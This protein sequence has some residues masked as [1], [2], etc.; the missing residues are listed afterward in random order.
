MAFTA[1]PPPLTAQKQTGAGVG[2]C[3]VQRP[4]SRCPAV[5]RARGGSWGRGHALTC[6][7]RPVACLKWRAWFPTCISHA[8]M[9]AMKPGCVQSCLCT[10]R[11]SVGPRRVFTQEGARGLGAELR[12]AV[13]AA[14]TLSERAAWPGHLSGAGAHCGSQ[15]LVITTDLGA[16]VGGSPP[17]SGPGESP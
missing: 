12:E 1:L 7:R 2:L 17:P 10:G 13:R 3:C 15:L 14:G 11:P 9:K 5:S 4:R 8:V 16:R 6:S